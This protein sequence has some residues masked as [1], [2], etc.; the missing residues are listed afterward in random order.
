MK[1]PI[2]W[3]ITPCN[4]L[5]FNRRFGEIYRRHLQDRRKSQARNLH[6]AEFATCSML[7]SCLAYSTLK[8]NATC[9]SE[10]SVDFQ[11]TTW[12]YIPEEITLH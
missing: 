12:R 11:Q 6:Q 3:H 9:Y 5:K 7:V 2:F 1:S 4:P 8:M 10:T